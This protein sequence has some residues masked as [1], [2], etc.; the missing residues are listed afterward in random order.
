MSKVITKEI[1][2]SLMDELDPLTKT[3]YDE[4][5]DYKK[6]FLFF[7]IKAGA[8]IQVGL[9]YLIILIIFSGLINKLLKGLIRTNEEYEK[10]PLW[11]LTLEL[12]VH[13]ACIIVG[14]YLGRK[15]VK[16]VPYIFDNIYGFKFSR[17][18]ELNGT[19][20]GA[21]SIMLFM[22][23]DLKEKIYYVV[24]RYEKLLNNSI[25]N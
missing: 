14:N 7:G 16:K 12:I 11:K 24:S 8:I 17:L 23:S 18:R 13:I 19:I 22:N 1:K 3:N 9:L 10:M 2:D 6:L 25:N 20:L 21:T 15:F 5:S 4:N